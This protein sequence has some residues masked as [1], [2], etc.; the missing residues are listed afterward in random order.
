MWGRDG[1][2]VAPPYVGVLMEAV[3]ADGLSLS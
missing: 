1:V 2:A 3:V